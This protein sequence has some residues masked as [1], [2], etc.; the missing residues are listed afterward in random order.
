MSKAKKKKSIIMAAK[1]IRQFQVPPLKKKK[2]SFHLI[3][4][5]KFYGCS[6]MIALNLSSRQKRCLW[7]HPMLFLQ[8]FLLVAY[9]LVKNW[10]TVYI[11]KDILYSKRSA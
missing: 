9:V 3:K 11:P 10:I 1:S 6:L 2:N 8:Y 7:P 5:V 4:V